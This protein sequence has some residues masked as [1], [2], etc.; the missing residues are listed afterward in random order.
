MSQVGADRVEVRGALGRPPPATLK[1]SATT[2]RGWRCIGTLTIV[3]IDAPAKARRSG[4][5]I[6]ERCRR[7]FAQRGWSD[8]AAVR[9]DVHGPET[10]YGP[11][12]AHPPLREAQLRLA[13]QH[14][15]REALELFAREIAPAGTSWSP[16]TTGS[17][18]GR[19]SVSPL[20]QPLAFAVERDAVTP[21]VRIGERTIR[22]P[23]AATGAPPAPPPPLPD[24]PHWAADGP[25]TAI[26]LV[27]LAW[28]RSGDKGDASNIGVIARRREWLPL[29]W[30]QVTPDAVRGWL[31]HLVKGRIERF[32]LPGL[33]AMNLL[34]HEALDGGGPMS[35]R[36]DPLGKGMAQMLLELPIAVPQALAAELADPRDTADVD[37][38]RAG[39]T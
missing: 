11:R 27:R 23:L 29:L 7:L 9:I 38:D 13:V 6:V 37:A 4:E 28:A 22:V 25:T 32:H 35:L 12:S 15:Q 26:P 31:G 36:V 17:G 21:V 30:A 3:G 16:G 1:V 39:P 14:A 8:F 24:P 20:I 18:S 10:L 2:L 33:A 5:A 34:L 19:P